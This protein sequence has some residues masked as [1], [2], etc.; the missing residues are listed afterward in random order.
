MAE[1]RDVVVLLPGITG[2]VLAR[3]DG[4]EVWS[5]SAGA[6]WRAVISLGGS[7]KD[8]ELDPGVADDGVT[9]PRLIPD[10]TIVPGL[11]KIDGYSR[12]E[13]YLIDQ[14]GLQPGRNYFPFPYD[15]RRDNRDNARRLQRQ[16]H[17]WLNAWRAS[18]GAAD[19][20]LVLVG[21]SM[22]GL[23]SRYFLEC[24]EGWKTTRALITLGTPHR[25]SL[26]AVDFLV[27]GMKKGIGP[28]GLDLTPLLRS[29]PSVYQLLPI[30]PCIDAGGAELARV[31][32]AAQAAALPNVD[33]ERAAQARAFHSEIEQAQAANAANAAYTEQ[34]YTLVPVV[35]IEQPTFQSARAASGK[36]ELL[37]S[38]D[39]QDMGGD[40]TVPRVSA[41]PIEMSTAQREVYAAEMHGSL[42]NAD[43]PLANIKGALTRS[44]ID[45]PR[46]RAPQPPAATLTLEMDDVVLPGEPLAVR[47]RAS[48]GVAAIDVQL[49]HIADGQTI[50]G[51][52]AGDDHSPWA[53]AS[54][55]ALAPGAWRV[56]ISAPGAAPVTDLAVVVPPA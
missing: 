21:H 52:L 37:R 54:F 45:L 42:Q 6:I 28:L 34:G 50:A 16:A 2:S 23:V 10:V 53:A 29:F 33:A 56:R 39:G 31:A 46:F 7:I 32:A 26:N 48:V 27:H 17:D 51:R 19:A 18:S 8:L 43:G 49:T 20:R 15:W 1:F 11:I 44:A 9:A 4:K 36:V 35:G 40:G 14:L 3:R 30:Y 47:A 55:D 13:R 41:T 25:G 12:I 24:L 5:P 22:G 38:Y